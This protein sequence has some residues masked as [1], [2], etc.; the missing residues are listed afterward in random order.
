MEGTLAQSRGREQSNQANHRACQGHAVCCQ[1]Q[2]MP[3]CSNRLFPHG[4]AEAVAPRL[5]LF[6]SPKQVLSLSPAKRPRLH[7]GACV[8]ETDSL[9]NAHC[10]QGAHFCT[11]VTSL[12]KEHRISKGHK[13]QRVK[14]PGWTRQDCGLAHRPLIRSW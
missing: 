3:G 9:P 14:I 4:Q 6:S 5:G 12:V 7:A 13:Q 8:N 11:M 2:A 10:I 1:G